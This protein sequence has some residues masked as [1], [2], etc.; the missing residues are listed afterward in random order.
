MAGYRWRGTVL[1]MPLEA[2]GAPA[3][4]PAKVPKPAPL[5]HC[6]TANGYKRHQKQGETACDPCKKGMAEY[7]RNYR[8][9]IRNGDVTPKKPFSD[10]RCGTYAGFRRH[11]KHNVPL[12]PPCRE[13]H[14][15]Y[16]RAYRAR[17]RKEE[18]WV[19][20]K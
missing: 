7:S 13:A 16:Q 18:T 11:T 3:P 8:A 15:E 2:P 19:G 9:K 4:E 12:C 5:T 1:D 14:Q 20:S 17:K 6:G 10:E